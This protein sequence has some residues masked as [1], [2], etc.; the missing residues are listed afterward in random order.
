MKGAGEKAL[1]ESE[2]RYR[3]LF[4]SCM[5][6]V[7]VHQPTAEGMPGKFIEVN[8]EA[9]RSYGYTREELLCLTPS[10]L[11]VSEL[12]SGIPGRIETLR[13]KGHVLFETVHVAKDG[14]RIPV[15]VHSRL[16]NFSGA[17]TVLSIVRDISDRKPIERIHKKSEAWL[18]T[19]L[20]ASIDRIRHVDRDLG[21]IWA[22]KTTTSALDMPT[23]S[24]IGQKCQKLFLDNDTPCEGCPTLK[25]LETG[26]VE[27]AVI[28]K[29]HMKGMEGKSYWDIYCV[30][31]KNEADQIETLIQVSR[32]IT[33]QKVAMDT[34]RQRE[35]TLAAILAASPAGITLVNNRILKWANESKHRMLGYPEGSL[36]GKNVR[37]LY[38]NDEEYERVGEELYS[39]A[40]AT[41]IGKAETR[42][43]KKDGT[44]IYCYL[45]GSPLDPQ[46]PS[47]GFIVAAMDISER[48]QAQEHIYS[49]SHELMKA[50]ESERQII[51]REL[52]D[53][54]AQDLSTLK[55]DI[56]TLW[57][58]EPQAFVNTRQKIS[59]LSKNLQQVIMAVRNLSYDLRP[60]SLDQLGPVQAIFQYCED[61]AEVTGLKVDY[62]SAGL[63]GLR[64]GFDTEINL[65]RLVQEGLNNIRKH[66]GATHA[67]VRLVA[68]HPHIILRIEDN[69]KGFDVK[70][71]L[72]SITKERRMGLR[73]MQER[74]NLLGGKIKIQ[75]RLG[76]GTKI[77]IE[78]P[79]KEKIG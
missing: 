8:A 29:P 63:E 26:R 4:N 28:C 53:R 78:V 57:D 75:S 79:Y 16:L 1:R 24:V 39:K 10:H 47:K 22:N 50:Q 60:P 45:Q 34:L 44:L 59:E 54:V 6:A 58:I 14:R 25:S 27:R 32:D 65:Y 12:A 40:K 33:K 70:K 30:P 5:D 11:S 15:E 20:D 49:L 56:D 21:I 48:K 74:V 38:P 7:F 37:E 76:Q 71:R 73:S 42:M 69:G 43:I 17:P 68:S 66:A 9:C 72:A 64:F 52:H 31:I 13:M 51:S 36:A 67:V 19:V 35:E 18:R 46:D 62:A 55:I 77:S 2:E 3:Q 23:E 41:G 61:F